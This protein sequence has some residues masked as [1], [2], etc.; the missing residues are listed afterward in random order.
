MKN[1]PLEILLMSV[2]AVLASVV[3]FRDL[4]DRM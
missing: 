2:V 4:F 1:R 3:A